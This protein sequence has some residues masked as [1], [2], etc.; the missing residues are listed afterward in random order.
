[1]KLVTKK[2]YQAT[3]QYSVRCPACKYCV[4]L[5]VKAHNALSTRLA[6]GGNDN[7]L[8]ILMRLITV[9]VWVEGPSSLQMSHKVFTSKAVIPGK[10]RVS[11]AFQI[12]PQ[13]DND[14][15]F[16]S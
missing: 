7:L 12:S 3:S 9:P 2:G 16:L 6:D 13:Q 8:W 15:I 10:V 14:D 11:S 5:R 1:M 4:I